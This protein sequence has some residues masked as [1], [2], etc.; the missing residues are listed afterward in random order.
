MPP[1]S[2]GC[3]DESIRTWHLLRNLMNTPRTTETVLKPEHG[4]SV[5]NEFLV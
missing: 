2:M 5:F 1:T 4:R 3:R